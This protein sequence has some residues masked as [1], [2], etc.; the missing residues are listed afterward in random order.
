MK[1]VLFLLLIAVSALSVSAQREYRSNQPNERYHYKNERNKDLGRKH[2]NVRNRESY[3]RQ[4][5]RIN[6]EF[7]AR[8]HS[9]RRNPFMSRN[10]KN[11]KIRELEMHR[12]V[13]L[14]E[15]RDRRRAR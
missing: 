13:A 5:D 9:I 6:H 12:R 14:N 3:R 4:M 1:R 7:D 15:F 8:I 2:G 10:Q 11:R